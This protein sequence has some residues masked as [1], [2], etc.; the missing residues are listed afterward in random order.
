MLDV[1]RAH[2]FAAALIREYRVATPSLDHPIAA[3]SGGNQQRIVIARALAQAPRVLI[4]VNPTRGLDI[5]ATVA[6]YALLTASAAAGAA[7]V[8]LSTDLDELA[9][10]CDRL[11]V[12]YRGRLSGPVAPSERA[13]VG[14]LMA[15]LA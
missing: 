4:A 9:A 1:G 14:A 12:L 11:L 2:A 6:V 3:L 8:L 7:V 15:G 13:R 10:V 5:A